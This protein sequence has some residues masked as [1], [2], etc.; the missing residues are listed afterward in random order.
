MNNKDQEQQAVRIIASA[1]GGALLGGY[2]LGPLGAAV[3]AAAGCYMADSLLKGENRQPIIGTSAY[4]IVLALR[5]D[6]FSVRRLQVFNQFSPR[7]SLEE[8]LC[9]SLYEDSKYMWKGTQTAF[10]SNMFVDMVQGKNVQLAKLDDEYAFRLIAI[11]ID[12]DIPGLDRGIDPLSRRDAFLSLAGNA[13][14][15]GVS[16][17]LLADSFLNKGFYKVVEI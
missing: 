9:G 14:I 11:E 5:I 7:S 8:A 1:A 10:N 17:L 16:P 15:I 6:S 2:V 12:K 13:K 3:G 4:F